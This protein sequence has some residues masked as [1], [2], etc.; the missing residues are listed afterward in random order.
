MIGLAKQA[1]YFYSIL[2]LVG[3]NTIT[4]LLSAKAEVYNYVEQERG[5]LKYALMVMADKPQTVLNRVS[6]IFTSCVSVGI[7][8]H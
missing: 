1:A 7:S 5:K 2:W 6:T 4:L 3:T 8:M